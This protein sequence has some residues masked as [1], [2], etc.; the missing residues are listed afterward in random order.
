MVNNKN[1]IVVLIIALLATSLFAASFEVQ[2]KTNNT[3]TT[4][5][6]I[7]VCLQIVNNSGAAVA[8]NTLKVR[9]YYTKEGTAAEQFTCD[10]AQIGNGLVN[11]SFATPGYLEI[12]FTGGNINNGANSGEI[13]T[14]TNKTDWSNYDQSNDYSFV[15][16]TSYSANS[17]ICLYQNGNLV[18]GTPSGGTI[19]PTATP[20]VV[21]TPPA[22]TGVGR[23]SVSPASQS[24][25]VGG[26]PVINLLVNSGTQ[27]VAAYGVTVT[28]PTANLSVVAADVVAGAQGFVSAVNTN[29]AGSI[30]ASG[31]DTAGK[32][33]GAALDLLKIT[34]T[35]NA[36]GTANIGVT[37]QT[38][39]DAAYANI[40]SPSG[41]GGTITV[42]GTVT[43]IPRTAT[44]TATVVIT[45]PAGTGVGRVS[46]SPASQT[47]AVGARPVIN[48]LVN[49]GTQMVAAYGVTVTYPAANL[50]VAAADVVAGAQGFVSAVNTNTAGSIVASGFDT[51]GK[52]PGAALDIL[53]ITFTATAA[54]TANLSV[55]VQSLTDG[56]YANIGTPTGSTA[57]ITIT[58]VA[59]TIPRTAT[60]TATVVTRTATRTATVVTR[61]ATR[62]ATVVVTATRTATVVVTTPAATGVGRISVSPASQSIAVGGRPVINLLLNSGTSMVASYGLTVTYTSSVLAV[63]A[64]DVVA[65]AQGFVSAVNTNTAG[66]IVASGFDTAGKGPGAAL[67]LVKITFTASAAGTATLG[68]TVQTL[69]DAAYATIGTP[70]GVGGTITV[71]GIVTTIAPTV[72][73]TATIAP[74]ATRTA[75]IAPTAT[76]TATIA[77]TATRTATIAPTATR[78]ATIAPTATRTA[79]IAPTATRT[80]TVV[81]TTPAAVVG[82]V[83]L[84]PATQTAA[85]NATVNQNVAVNT[86]TELCAA[87]GVTIAYPSNMLSITTAGVTAGAQ[88]FVSA[89]NP[90]TAGSLVISGFDTAGK[91]PSAALALINIAWTSL[92]VAGTANMT[93]TVQTLT[94]A[95]YANIGTPTGSTATITLN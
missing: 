83:S 4:N 94:N 34:F 68:L 58:G 7:S 2:Y 85:R 79:T 36:S 8:M 67:D 35:A 20:P 28:Y 92:N 9:Y 25:S 14:R 57:T 46:I 81:V 11:G 47:V 63:V 89:V 93:L 87:Y 77:P 37:V 27:M 15:A 90:N 44:R 42:G 32:G 70:S 72:T 5:N 82:K 61:T 84:L 71:T 60:R 80:A 21:T 43:T 69:T 48:L 24:T 1:L 13:Q 12:G 16:Q 56:A 19:I 3:G 73:R 31:F 41:A 64:A 33:P 75:T 53:K 39:T 23:V 50:S 38:L 26:R 78:T 45:T 65:G 55:T 17:K 88:G 74:T 10:W 49:S 86:G 51:A 62:T 76:R 18:W 52:G 91:G 59:T 66:S 22:G 6:T 30:V 95:S 29:T 54:A 40:G